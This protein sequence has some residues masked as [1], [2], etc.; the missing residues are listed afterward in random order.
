MEASFVALLPGLALV[1]VRLWAVLR[2]QVLWRA[3]VGPLWPVLAAG[4]AVAMAPLVRPPALVPGPDPGEWVLALGL[5]L[6]A[7][8]AWGIVVSLPANAVIGAGLS[9]ARI[10]RAPPR[11]LAALAV[12]VAT[13]TALALGLHH[14]L[15]EGLVASTEVLP[16]GDPSAAVALSGAEG[17]TW[18][19]RGA[20][21]LTLLGLALATPVLL[22]AAV[23]DVALGA[24][25]AGP[26]PA[27]AVVDPVR[28]WARAALA[29]VALGASW[30]AYGEVWARAVL[31][32]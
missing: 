19:I 16:V 25:A 5:E 29:L 8:T 1:V 11:P 18:A 31:P 23:V 10:L 24:V 21:A 15:L 7:G 14:P 13:A 9:A 26:R 3:A 27:A 12:A 22:C 28:R 20:T 17:L 6:A 30:A 4:L 32:P 2:A